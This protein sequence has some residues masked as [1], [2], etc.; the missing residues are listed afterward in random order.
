MDREIMHHMCKAQMD[1]RPR[2]AFPSRL[3]WLES[4]QLAL[5]PLLTVRP[6]VFLYRAEAILIPGDPAELYY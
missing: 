6:V 5:H 1:P 4:L 3:C 2:S